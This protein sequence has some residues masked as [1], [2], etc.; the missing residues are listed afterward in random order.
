MAAPT[1]TGTTTHEGVDPGVSLAAPAHNAGDLLVA[2]MSSHAIP[3]VSSAGFDEDGET[4]TRVEEHNTGYTFPEPETSVWFAVAVADRPSGYTI[5]IDYVGASVRYQVVFL[6]IAGGTVE[7]G[8]A[9][10]GSGSA[11]TSISATGHTTTVDDCLVLYACGA[12]RVSAGTAISVSGWTNASLTGFAEVDEIGFHGGSEDWVI[13][14]A[15]GVKDTAGATG[16]ATATLST[17][18]FAGMCSVSI[19]PGVSSLWTVGT[20]RF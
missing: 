7:N 4:W 14:V 8:S 16:T 2:C 17:A 9:D 5:D 18:A 11:V 10:N 1:I 20:I 15:A 12:A 19:E 6:T 13:S 3:T